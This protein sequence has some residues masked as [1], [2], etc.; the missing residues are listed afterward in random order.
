MNELTPEELVECFVFPVKLT[1]KQK[2]EADQQLKEARERNRVE[3]SEKGLIRSDLLQLRFQI[4]HY[5]KQ[6]DFDPKLT[7]SH[8]LKEYVNIFSKKRKDFAAEIGIDES[9]LSQFI[10][11]HRMPPDYITIRLELHSNNLIPAEYWYRL[12]EKEREHHIKTDKA[13][14]I[15][16]MKHVVRNGQFSIRN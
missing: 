9:L 10:N 14:R 12:V 2:K 8:F 3:F 7:F 6:D 11:T 13:L 5:L 4:E 1:A 15:K 16:E